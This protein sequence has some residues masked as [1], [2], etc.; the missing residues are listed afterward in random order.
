MLRAGANVVA[1]D[2]SE[3][4]LKLARRKVIAE[5]LPGRAD[6]VAGTAENL[7]LCERTFD[8]G[9]IFGSLHHFSDPAAGL[10]AIARIIKPNGQFY[11]MEPHDSPVRFI[12]DWMMRHWNRWKEEANDDP[13]FT[14]AKFE[15]WLNA[16]GL[17]ARIYYSTYLPPHLFYLINRHGGEWL[18]ALTDAVFGSIPGLRSLG[19]VIIAEAI[20]R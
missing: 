20:K 13:L 12:F 17:D 11:L 6:F 19:G 5:S 10:L 4:L 15:D 7:P 2:L 18:L 8:A 1:V 9:L 3:D 14:R 16:I